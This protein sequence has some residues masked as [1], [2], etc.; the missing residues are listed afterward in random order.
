LGF[1]VAFIITISAGISKVY[2]E[3]SSTLLMV[4]GGLSLVILS[5]VFASLAKKMHNKI[6]K[7]KDL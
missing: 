4:I 6:K 3:E 1:I 2:L 7:L 5:V